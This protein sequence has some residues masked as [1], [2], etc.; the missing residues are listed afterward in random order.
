MA[1]TS[2]NMNMSWKGKKSSLMQNYKLAFTELFL[3]R[4]PVSQ[5]PLLEKKFISPIISH[6]KP[7]PVLPPGTLNSLYSQWHI[8]RA[9]GMAW[10]ILGHVTQVV[11]SSGYICQ[12][13]SWKLCS[14]VDF[15]VN[16]R[17][18]NAQTSFYKSLHKRKILQSQPRKLFWDMGRTHMSRWSLQECHTLSSI[19]SRSVHFKSIHTMTLNLGTKMGVPA[20]CLEAPKRGQSVLTVTFKIS[21]HWKNWTLY[22]LEQ[23]LLIFFSCQNNSFLIP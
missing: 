21:S 14:I 11:S 12:L 4:D 5:E 9:S 8:Q 17:V 16:K 15:I 2:R 18:Y 10:S 20:C 23:I 3:C 1:H 7:K 6:L 22:F 19:F 13:L